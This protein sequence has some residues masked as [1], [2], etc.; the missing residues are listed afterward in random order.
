MRDAVVSR[1]DACD[2]YISAAAPADFRPEVESSEK[3]KKKGDLEIK[4]AKNPDIAQELGAVK[5]HQKIIIFAA[6]SQN[7]IENAEDKL[8]KKNADMVVANDITKEGAG[9]AADTNIV[10]IIKTGGSAKDYPIM[11][12]KELAELILKELKALFGE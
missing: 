2:A 4:F 7:L 5:S 6:E 1:F 12:K 10:S 8:E 11:P 3:I 9:F